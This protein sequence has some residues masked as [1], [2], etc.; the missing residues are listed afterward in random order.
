M[1]FFTHWFLFC[2]V[3]CHAFSDFSITEDELNEID[4]HLT[5]LELNLEITK[6]ELMK[7]STLLAQLK[8]QTMYLE[9][10]LEASEKYSAQLEK[11]VKFRNN[12]I[13]TLSI[14]IPLSLITGFLFSFLL[15]R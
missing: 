14:A 7:S 1:K 9:R 3:V 5:T 8:N 10:K 15:L 2:V 11:G 13:I 6:E 12:V 4:R